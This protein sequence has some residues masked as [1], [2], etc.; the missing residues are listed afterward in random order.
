MF[1]TGWRHLPIS[2]PQQTIL[3]E[4]RKILWRACCPKD[5]QESKNLGIFFVIHFRHLDTGFSL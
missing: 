4:S 5:D 2:F 1:P 3:W